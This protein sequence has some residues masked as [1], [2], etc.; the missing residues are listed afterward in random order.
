ML[1]FAAIILPLSTIRNYQKL[2]SRIEPVE[3][4]EFSISLKILKKILKKKKVIEN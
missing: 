3:Q 4:L 1:A 2:N